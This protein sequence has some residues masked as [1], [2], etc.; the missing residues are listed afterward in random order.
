MKI[1]YI[2]LNYPDH[3]ESYAVNPKRYGGGR[4][5]AA[6]AKELIPDFH[7]F[8]SENSF[9]DLSDQDKISHCHVINNEQQKLIRDGAPI[10]EVIPETQDIDIFVHHFSNI[11]INTNK[12]QIIW[13][14]GYREHIHPKNKH[15]MLYSRNRQQP[16]ITHTNHQ[17]YDVV[18][19]VPMS[20]TFEYNTKENFIFQCTRHVP[21]FGSI[22]VA[23]LCNHFKI[24]CI[25]AG[26]INNNYPLLQYIDNIN[27]FYI[28]S[29]SNEE[30]IKY[31]KK[32]RLYTFLHSWP[33]PFN[34]SAIDALAYGTPIVSTSIGFWPDL[35][36]ENKNGF[37]INDENAFISAWEKSL[38]IDQ[39]NC[40]NSAQNY[41]I[42]KMIKSFYQSIKNC[43]ESF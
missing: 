19:G 36:E 25:F 38:N 29:V 12:P 18:I 23:R 35:V 10:S 34:L 31:T 28:G 8:S 17:I 39:K 24:Q 5:F 13:C 22:N 43:Y 2:D 40:F 4:I 15:V 20:D 42:E 6:W 21:E 14:L 16:V 9:Q 7:L 41:T 1:G 33:T 3:Y 27:T 26:P 11:H 37:I 32:A 30:K